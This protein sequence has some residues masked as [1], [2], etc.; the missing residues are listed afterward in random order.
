MDVVLNILMILEGF[1]QG[2]ISLGVAKIL[3]RNSLWLA[4][5]LYILEGLGDISDEVFAVFQ[6]AGQT[7]QIGADTGGGQ[8]LVGHLPVS[9]RGGVQAAGAGVGNVGLDGTQLQ[10]LHKGFSSFSATD[11]TERNNATGAV[12]HIFLSQIVILITL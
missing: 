9:G 6:T 3:F 10:M 12:G 1:L 5:L 7:D 2:K 11:Q 4:F 8:L